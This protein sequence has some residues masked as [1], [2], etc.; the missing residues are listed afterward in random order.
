VKL[1]KNRKN[2]QRPKSCCPSSANDSA[3]QS[4]RVLYE[5]ACLL[6]EQGEYSEATCLYRQ[7]EPIVT[8]HCLKALLQNDLAVLAIVG[9]NNERTCMGFAA[10][11]AIDSGCEVARA[12]LSLLESELTGAPDGSAAQPGAPAPPTLAGGDERVRVALVS[13]YRRRWR[14]DGQSKSSAMMM[15]IAMRERWHHA[16]TDHLCDR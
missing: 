12:N 2:R 14:T 16:G 9:D 15:C 3:E 1:S 11:L 13:F 8:D 4:L 10:A 5:R 7:L 6:A